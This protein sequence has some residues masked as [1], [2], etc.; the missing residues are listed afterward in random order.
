MH[1]L[2]WISKKIETSLTVEKSHMA[3][4]KRILPWITGSK[5]GSSCTQNGIVSHEFQ[6][7]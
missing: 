3:E 5:Y 7:R 4:S 1:K 6:K 2:N